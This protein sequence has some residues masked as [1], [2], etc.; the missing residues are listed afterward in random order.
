MKSCGNRAPSVGGS[1]GVLVTVAG[2]AAQ[3]R[4]AVSGAG[5]CQTD[6]L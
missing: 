4:E 1:G 5:L 3:S 2:C 6:G